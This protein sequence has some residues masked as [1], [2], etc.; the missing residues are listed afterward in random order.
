MKHE[1]IKRTLGVSATVL[2]TSGILFTSI[3]AMADVPQ[4][5]MTETGISD[6]Q[7]G[8]HKVVNGIFDANAKGEAS[9]RITGNEGQ[10]LA[11]KKFEL[12]Q[13]FNCKNAAKK[14][15]INYSF[16]SK[17]Q[18]AVQTVVFRALQKA[19]ALTESEQKPSDITEYRAIDYIQS[20]NTNPVEGAETTGVENGYYS[21]FRYFAEDLRTE[22][23][24]EGIDGMFIK[25][26]SPSA[27]NTATITGLPYG[28][29]IIDERSTSTLP[30]LDPQDH[31]NPT[32]QWFASSMLMVDT[33][34]RSV[35]MHV[36]SD[37]P[38]VSK[39]IQEDDHR[40]VIG[41]DGYNDIGDYEIGQ[42]IPY[43]YLSAVPD[44]NGKDHY[45]YAFH[46]HA[47]Q[48][49]TPY[50]E[51]EDSKV[52]PK[53][54]G[55]HI[56]IIGKDASG[57]AKK[58]ALKTTEYKIETADSPDLKPDGK[59][60]IIDQGDS[61]AVSITD[62]KT[63][64][65]REFPHFDKNHHNDYSDETVEVD[66]TMTLNDK[67]ADRTGRAGFENQVRLEYSNNMDSNG[68]GDTGYTPWD[69]VVAFTFKLNGLKENDHGE[70]LANAHFRIYAD[71]QMKQEILL[72]KKATG[73]GSAAYIVVNRDSVGG[74]DHISK[75][76]QKGEEIVSDS[77]GNFV[78]CG[79]DGQT[80]YLK[81]TVA[82]DGYRLLKKPI[83]L[84]IKP[85]Y[86]KDRN[87]YVQ[88][89]GATDAV[90]QKLDISAQIDSFYKGVEKQSKKALKTDVNDGSGN[91]VVVNEIGSKL[92][93]TGSSA[94]LILLGSGI[95]LMGT[96]VILDKKAKRTEQ[97]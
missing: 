84:T 10:T 58:Y 95:A 73:N 72:K 25:V 82:P 88:G 43:R 3:P 11:G 32:D 38:E 94:M 33:L 36:K 23:K 27:Q 79:L 77:K 56:T 85:T 35:E 48:A 29:Y 39:K 9:V 67:A 59:S 69:T 34:N 92:P 50:L 24:N 87:A 53:Q 75:N 55:V 81:E 31:N 14:E 83:E 64:V 46:D 90:L 37:Y 63:I 97:D 13:I 71:P 21:A 18:T 8:D 51:T 61:F 30:N 16:N 89:G 45:F 91:L 70:S 57:K 1:F 15:S 20:L 76:E 66:E 12:F 62:L 2:L 44:M 7:I 47:D 28:Y 6:E 96:V 54:K 4:S 42:S 52:N 22:I 40:E 93:M 74:D 60:R 68:G 49:L 19:G 78:I 65:D 86:M 80:Y 17:Y 26:D 41:N 5:S